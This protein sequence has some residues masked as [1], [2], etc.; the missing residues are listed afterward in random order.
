MYWLRIIVK[1]EQ[2]NFIQELSFHG[3]LRREAHIIA[4]DRPLA[5]FHKYGFLGISSSHDDQ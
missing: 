2:D 5:G 3:R 1:R 4:G